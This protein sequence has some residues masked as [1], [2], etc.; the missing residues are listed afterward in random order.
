MSLEVGLVVA[1][2]VALAAMAQTVTGF[3]FALLVVPPVSLVL[4]PADA[5]AL[6]LV[7]LLLAN[8]SLVVTEGRSLD[9]SASRW[10]LGGCVVG[11]P[12]GM[13]ALRAASADALRLA[14]AVA[15]VVTVVIV[16]AERPAL[17]RD[18]GTLVVAGVLTGALTTSL[19][20]SG[21][22]TVLALQGR[23]LE[24]AAFRSTVGLVLGASSAVGVAMFAADGRLGGPVPAAVAIG[25]PAQL[26]GW[27]AGL[28]VRPLVPAEWFRRAV[29]ALLLVGA[30]LAAGS[31]LT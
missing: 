15:V 6:S 2:V 14:V 19:T 21:P 28:R 7:L 16:V 8:V 1:A 4:E 20:T 26:F 23:G 9:R 25:V 30:G 11:L 5:V 10:L 29:I 13:M 22:P 12:L 17:G 31:A 24:P 18:R 27:G 3:G